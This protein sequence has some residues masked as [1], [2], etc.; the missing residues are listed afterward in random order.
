MYC[1]RWIF[2]CT[3]CCYMLMHTSN[4]TAPARNYIHVKE[5]KI[6]ICTY[7]MNVTKA[8]LTMTCSASPLFP[9]IR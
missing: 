9:N 4:H 2:I 8:A 1:A 5:A 7:K 6:S 3:Q